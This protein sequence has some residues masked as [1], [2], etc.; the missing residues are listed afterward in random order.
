M[1]GTRSASLATAAGGHGWFLAVFPLFAVAV[2]AVFAAQLLRRFLSRRR[3]F[4]GLWAVALAMFA[5]ASFAM[6][7]GVAT[8][9]GPLEF[10]VYWLLGAVLN[11][12]FLFAGELYLLAQRRA[13]ADW[14]LAALMVGTVFAA[15]KVMTAPVDTAALAK[16]LPLGKQVFGDESAAYRIAQVY[17]FPA[18]FLLLGGIVWSA[19]QMRRQ[20]QLRS[21]V[22]GTLAIA[23]GATIVAIGSGIGAG[24]NIVPLFSVSLAAGV[25]VM[26][27][28]FRA[29][30]RPGAPPHPAASPAAS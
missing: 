29:V 12:P 21:R 17:A 27:A 14:A 22:A 11:V 10:R 26:Y 28:G 24:F 20:P 13:V 2:A 23:I 4:E 15:W 7:L 19:W 6:F 8:G 25:T 9:W 16:A 18:Y 3:P 1:S 30:T 5:V